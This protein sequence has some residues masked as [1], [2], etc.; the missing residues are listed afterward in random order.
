MFQ[1]KPK[2]RR[3]SRRGT[4]I[5][6]VAVSITLLLG[7]VAISL[8]GGMLQDNKRRL[9]NVADSA[10][11]AAGSKLYENYPS[12]ISTNTEDPGGQAAAAAQNSATNNGFA[13]NG[14]TTTVTVHIPPTS[15]PFTGRRGFAEVIV[16]YQQ[17][18]YFSAIWGSS[19]T[20]IRA[21]AVAKAFWGGTGNGVI[22]LDPSV[23]HALDGSGTGSVTVTGGANMIVNSNDTEAGRQTGGGSLTAINFQVT[24]GTV[25]SFNGTVETGTL[26]TPDPFAYLPAP[27]G[28]PDGTITTTN[29]K[30]GNKLYVVTPGKH[31]NLPSL[32]VGDIMVFK[33]ASYNSVGGIY[34]LE[35]GG[36]SSQGGTLIMDSSTT[37]GIMIYN[38]PNSN[39]ASQ[40]INISGNDLGTVNLSGLTSGPYAGILFFQK[41]SADQAMSVAGQGSFSLTGTFYAANANLQITGNGDATIGSQY[42]SKT[43]NL[44]GN[45]NITIDYSPEGTA[46]KR[47]VRLV[48]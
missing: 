25:G 34:S 31:Y 16:V 9:Q 2:A 6:M 11:L 45:G 22:V 19:A 39:A 13:H 7:V 32:Q 33:Q 8:D 30:T 44:S 4:V 46:R 42:V 41:R 38:N 10:A 28:L 27:S 29:L 5:V 43:L 15:G 21:R 40:G 14:T 1:Q 3:T 12:I 20:P 37:G 35:S 36:L 24:G 18:R 48:E 26:P 23:S 17:P 47:E